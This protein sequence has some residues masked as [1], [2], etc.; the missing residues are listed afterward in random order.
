MRRDQLQAT[1]GAFR[2]L[3]PAQKK[4]L[5][6]RRRAWNKALKPITDAMRRSK[7]ITGEDLAIRI[8]AENAR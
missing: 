7:I 8:N 1:P 3:T 6:Q 2:R 5:E 4:K